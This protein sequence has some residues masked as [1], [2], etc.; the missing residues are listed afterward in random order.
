MQAVGGTAMSGVAGTPGGAGI[1]ATPTPPPAK[2]CESAASPRRSTVW[3]AHED[4][5]RQQRRLAVRKNC[6]EVYLETS[7]TILDGS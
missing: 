6:Y 7:P 2:D 1:S 4:G 5:G 3:S